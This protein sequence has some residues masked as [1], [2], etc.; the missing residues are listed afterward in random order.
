MTAPVET[1]A[2]ELDT[3]IPENAVPIRL[4]VM[5]VEGMDT[6]DGRYIAP[7]ALTVRTLPIPL[8]AQTRHI[9]GADGD[10]ATWHVGAITAA[11]RVPGPS[12]IQM[13]TGEPF[14][15]GT[16][17][18][19]GTAGWMYTDVPADPQKSAYTLVKDGALRGNS[20]DLSAVDAEFEYDDDSDQPRRIVMHSGAIAATTL[21]GQPA[22]PDAYV[23]LD[24]VALEPA[25]MVAG[26]TPMWRSSDIGDDCSPC[27]AGDT[28]TADAATVADLEALAVGDDL[29]PPEP[30]APRHTGG[31]VALIPTDPGVLAVEGGDPVEELHLTLAYLGDDVTD[32]ESE[33]VEAA[34][35]VVREATDFQAMRAREVADAV[36]RGEE[37]PATPQGAAE[38]RALLAGQRGPVTLSVFSHA[39]FN[40][41]GDN[42]HDPATVY[43]M[44]GS[45][46]RADV[47]GMADYIQYRMRD[48]LGDVT[49][50]EQH[51][52]YVPHVTAGY[53][54]D[55]KALTYTGPVTFD[56]MRLAL[57]D[58]VTDYPLGG[59]SVI[60]ASA[61]APL[62]P[63]AWFA[64]PG[65]NGPTAL[66]VD[67][68]G[69]VYG[70]LACWG[71]C[72][73]GFQGKC[74]TPPRSA[75]NYA[76]FK[77]HSTRVLNEDGKTVTIPVGYG[78]ISTGH[79]DI[80]ANALA[81]VEH[82]DNTGTAAFELAI[83]EDRHG[84]WVAGALMPGL[85]ETQEHRARGTVFSGD[86]R[87]IRGKLELVASLGV[88][89]GGFPVPRAR[90]AS[91]QVLALVA[92][93][94]LQAPESG[95]VNLSVDRASALAEVDDLAVV[96]EWVKDQR[97]QAQAHSLLAQIDAATVAADASL[98]L[99]EVEVSL[100]YALEAD[101]PWFDL[102]ESALLESDFD[103]TIEALA[104]EGLAG[105]KLHLPPYIKRIANHLKKEGMEE[106][107]A[108]AT[109]VN[110]A[111]KMCATGDTSLPGD[112]DVNPGSRA[113][114]CKA[115]AQWKADRPGAT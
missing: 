9:H 6:A 12:V 73:I 98:A 48:Q 91:G 85:S 44:D 72:H 35:A 19:V 84:I 51:R 10:A 52:P 8:Y 13:S 39:V 99:F 94:V 11:E 30:D 45:G 115:V 108:I 7:G 83:G 106:G 101:H 37:P 81:A 18:W 5:A 96:I 70:H 75:S 76:Y 57:G 68:D 55:P 34:H 65:L 1:D 62:R 2:P 112:Q 25:P 63:A 104:A 59:G 111:K 102:G 24:G 78:T 28:L 103:A 15:D 46:D 82:Y 4:P 42:G 92:A 29:E 3:E 41:N 109:A 27:A 58:Q 67:D 79:A 38:E 69:R 54:V 88:N 71:T 20:V 64:D 56:R 32:W 43:L 60:T 49:F 114:A 50:P 36:R 90:V 77:V 80:R 31:M 16:F 93:G 105:K 66:T 40:P 61:A 17:V 86:W 21:V 95:S 113:Q 33:M 97:L 110:A 22:F 100:L 23:E 107:R 26:G 89:T 53:G 87:P 47:D 74:V 14:P